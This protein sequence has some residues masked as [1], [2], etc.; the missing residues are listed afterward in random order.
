MSRRH[1]LLGRYW[2]RLSLQSVA[3]GLADRHA[4]V[5]SPGYWR[6]PAILPVRGT[7]RLCLDLPGDSEG[8]GAIA[9]A[10]P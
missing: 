1:R 5:R 4:T 7:G 9:I 10:A 3:I 6:I 8:L 2:A